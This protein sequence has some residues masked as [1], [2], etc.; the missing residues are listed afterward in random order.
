MEADISIWRKPG[1]F[2]F[3]LTE[4]SF[5]IRLP[6]QTQVSLVLFAQIEMQ[7]TDSA[8]NSR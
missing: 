4:H 5:L 1:H 2:Y 7:G 6:N 8:A 3:A